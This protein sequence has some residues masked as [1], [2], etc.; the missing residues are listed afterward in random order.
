MGGELMPRCAVAEVLL[1]EDPFRF[2][3]TCTTRSSMDWGVGPESG[4]EYGPDWVYGSHVR[5][6]EQHGMALGASCNM[7]WY[8]SNM[9]WY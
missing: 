9:A 5:C 4:L 1:P 7:A 6:N 8:S 3:S 2:V